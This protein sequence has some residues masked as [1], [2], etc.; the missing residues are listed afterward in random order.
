MIVGYLCA[1]PKMEIQLHFK[2]LIK[3]KPHIRIM[4]NSVFEPLMWNI[5][6][7]WYIIQN[8]K[9]KHLEP[10]LLGMGVH[11]KPV[12]TIK[13]TEIHNTAE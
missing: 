1:I 12:T 4:G 5:N 9:Q 6:M 2:N 11:S 10:Q 8:L 3:R 7:K 13:N